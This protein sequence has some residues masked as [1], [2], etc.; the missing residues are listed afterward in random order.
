[1]S[2]G[3]VKQSN[4]QS[5][6]G[7]IAGVAT[8]LI[9]SIFATSG[10]A[11]DHMEAPGALADP[12]AD[13]ADLYTW[14]T[15]NGTIVAALTFDGLAAPGEAASWDSDVLYGI[16]IDSDGDNLADQDIWVRFGQNG[17]GEWGMQVVGLPGASGD[18]VGP[19]ETNLEVPEA[20][21]LKVFA[22]R[23]DDPFFFD[24]A[25]YSDTLMT[26]TL[27]FTATDAFAGF[28]ATAIVVE[29]DASAALAGGTTG[30]LW[31]TT[32]RL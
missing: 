28:N 19:V 12:A 31:A 18:V 24:L 25:G 32:S 2:I 29:M 30:Q 1:M 11:A 20:T 10:N 26:G 23:R 7:R 17:A 8:L 14:G 21:D 13:I 15:G 9:T 5:P 22:G 16:H 4:N 3:R 6:I 27:S